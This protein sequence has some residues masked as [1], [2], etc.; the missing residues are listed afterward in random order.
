MSIASRLLAAAVAV[1]CALP[2]ATLSADGPPDGFYRYPAIGGGMIVFASEGDLWKVPAGGGVAI[3]LTAHEGEECFSRISPDG[4]LVAFTAQYEGNVSTLDPL[5]FAELTRY[6]GKNAFPM[7]ANDGR[8]Y[9][10]TDRW[11]RPNLASMLPDGSNVR[12]LTRFDDY[13]VR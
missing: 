3:R 1:L 9:F 10:V 11:R 7:W 12:R 13:D 8:I 5:S 6:D 4:T 2:S